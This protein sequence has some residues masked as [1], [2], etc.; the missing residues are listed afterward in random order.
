MSE[1]AH[2]I[3]GTELT[4]SEQR[5]VDAYDA[6]AKLHGDPELAPTAKA[7]LAEAIASLWQVLNNLALTDDR[8][9]V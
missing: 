4:A 1:T 6:L 3:L 5:L 2:D 9:A 7:G 8:P